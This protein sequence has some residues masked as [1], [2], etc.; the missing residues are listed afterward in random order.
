MLVCADDMPGESAKPR[1]LERGD[2]LDVE[3]AYRH[4][5]DR[6]MAGRYPL[7]GLIFLGLMAGA[8]VI[9]WLYFPQRWWELAVCYT[10][11][12]AIVS[13]CIA[14]LRV[15]PGHVFGIV[16]A[17]SVAAT[18]SLAAYLALVQ[19]SAELCLLSM[20]GMLTGQVVQFPWGVRGQA[21]AALAAIAAY[22]W[23]LWVGSLPTLPVPYGLFALAAHALMTVLGAQL[24]DSYRFAAFREASEAAHHAAESAR[25]NAAKGEFLATVS[26]EVRTP[27][28]IIVG[29]T[30]LLLEQAFARPEEQYDALRSIHHNSR[31]LLDLIQSMLDLN[32]IESGRVPLVIEEFPVAAALDGLRAG[33]PANWCRPGVELIWQSNDGATRMHSDRAKLETV[34]RNLV[35]NALKYTDVG[36]VTISAHG[37]PERGR[38]RFTV[39]DTGQGIDAGDLD[40]IFEMF[41]QGSNG[42]PLGGG[43]GLGLYIAK[44]LTESLGG[45]IA[46]ASTPGAGSRFTVTL[47]LEVRE[48]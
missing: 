26:H 33:L 18:F 40:V 24:L 36:S 46:V 41:R 23:A 5:T 34:L 22:L 32:R 35:H 2:L 6:L 3:A 28:N 1:G 48:R 21:A 27:L 7:S 43:V 15:F 37:E 17:S 14:A 9:E 11:F 19:R 4:A 45:A 16:L 12:I 31:Q 38:V 29:Y 8:C 42:A 47:P 25:A 39:A 44:R 30:D 20:I 10:T 13:A